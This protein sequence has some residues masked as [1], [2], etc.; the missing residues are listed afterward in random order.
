[1]FAIVY[2]PQASMAGFWWPW[3]IKDHMVAGEYAAYNRRIVLPQY[4]KEKTCCQKSVI[5]LFL[6]NRGVGRVSP[7]HGID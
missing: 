2:G 3:F 5:F 7:C 4:Q 6:L 1:M